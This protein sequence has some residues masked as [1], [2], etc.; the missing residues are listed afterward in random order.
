[1]H[2]REGLVLYLVNYHDGEKSRPIL[3]RG[4]LSEKVVPYGEP[5]PNW[6][7]LVIS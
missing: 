7:L 4:S 6:S 2:P 3:Y 1:M 5:D